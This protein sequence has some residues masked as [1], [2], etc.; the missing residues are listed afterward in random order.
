M[1]VFVC[2]YLHAS[3]MF[4]WFSGAAVE[5]LSMCKLP[6]WLCVTVCV[7]APLLAVESQGPVFSLEGGDGEEADVELC[8]ATWATA[9]PGTHVRTVCSA[10][11][12]KISNTRD[13]Y[14]QHNWIILVM[15]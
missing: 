15:S 14:I 3:E 8:W 4:C 5:W 2:E 7:D 1:S 6:V 11:T 12:N 13:T 10:I 9:K